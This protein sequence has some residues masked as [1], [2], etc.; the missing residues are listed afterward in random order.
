MKKY[1]VYVEETSYGFVTVEAE[2]EEEAYE[3]AEDMYFE[4]QVNWTGGDWRTRD[5]Q[6]V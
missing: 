4:G 3:K 6:E 2:S 5:C 1:E